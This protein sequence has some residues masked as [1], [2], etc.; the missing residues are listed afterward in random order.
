MNHLSYKRIGKGYPGSTTM[1]ELRPSFA[2]Y[3][4]NS[5]M[6]APSTIRENV[7][8]VFELLDYLKAHSKAGN[9]AEPPV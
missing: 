7:L 1:P 5:K 9:A 4:E 6:P 2:G 3:G 8:Q